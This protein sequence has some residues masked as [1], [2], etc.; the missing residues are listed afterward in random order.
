LPDPFS[1]LPP[2]HGP[3]NAG[4]YLT[5]LPDLSVLEHLVS[6]KDS[7]ISTFKNSAYLARYLA[8]VTYRGGLKPVIEHGLK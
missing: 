7:T 3:T 4:E 5:S 2:D 1:L 6:F 8:K